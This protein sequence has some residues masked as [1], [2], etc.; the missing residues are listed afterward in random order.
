MQLCRFNDNR[1][2]LV[3]EDQVLDVTDTLDSLPQYRYPLPRVDPFIARLDELMPRIEAS[4]RNATALPLADIR[5]LSPVA[6]PGKI[7]AAPVNY[8]KHLIE[9]RADPGIHHANQIAEI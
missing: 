3:V 1:L 9:A 2:G 7:V 5:I 6:S 4:A 8:K